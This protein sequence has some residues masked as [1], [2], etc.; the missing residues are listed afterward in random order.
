MQ[1]E[2]HKDSALPDEV[3]NRIVVEAIN[4]GW[5]KYAGRKEKIISINSF[6]KLTSEN[7][8]LKYFG[9]TSENIMNAAKSYS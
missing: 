3:N 5:Q 9:I 4:D 2:E 8:S 6:E 7:E 1:N